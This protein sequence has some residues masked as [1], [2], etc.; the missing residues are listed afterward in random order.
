MPPVV[1]S[2]EGGAGGA[3][4]G[5]ALMKGMISVEEWWAA[6]KMDFHLCFK[7]LTDVFFFRTG[8]ANNGKQCICCKKDIKNIIQRTK[9]EFFFTVVAPGGEAFTDEQGAEI[10]MQ[11]DEDDDVMCHTCYTVGMIA[12]SFIQTQTKR[13]RLRH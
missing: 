11:P 6:H 7:Q 4:A 5:G 10:V 13:T 12:T 9:A 8:K 3:A 2:P 1:E